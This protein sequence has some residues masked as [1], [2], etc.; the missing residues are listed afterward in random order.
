MK[1]NLVMSRTYVT[2]MIVVADDEASAWDWININAEAIY[3][4]ELEQMNVINEELSLEPVTPSQ[5]EVEEL[6]D[7]VC[8]INQKL[9]EYSHIE[10]F[11]PS[12]MHEALAK[13]IAPVVETHNVS[14]NYMGFTTEAYKYVDELNQLIGRKAFS[15][16]T[17]NV[18][19]N[20]YTNWIIFGNDITDEEIDRLNLSQDFIID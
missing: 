13:M 4:A 17:T 1:Y 19:Q 5:N 16:R 20:P 15:C 6:A 18:D 10:D 11:I 12:E 9:Q 3:E 8:H 2:E 14:T 7:L